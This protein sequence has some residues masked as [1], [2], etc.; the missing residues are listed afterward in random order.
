M[1]TLK[2]RTIALLESRKSEELAALV[3]RLDGAPVTAPAVREVPDA[4]FGARIDA[5]AA[6]RF[7]VTIFLTGVGVSALLREAENRGC[8]REILGALGRATVACRG[9]KP[10]AVLKRHGL[11]AQIVSTKPHTTRE[12]LD[13]LDHVDLHGR[14]VLL[15]HYGE[16]N[17]VV[18]DAV[19]ARGATLEEACPYAWALPDDVAPILAVVQNAID[20]RIDG[21]LFTSQVQCR[22][23]FQIAGDV[24]LADALARSLNRDIVVGAVG[25]VCAEAL[26]DLG[27]RPDVIPA[28]PNMASLI[29][30]LGDYFE[31]TGSMR[32]SG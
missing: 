9:P 29:T 23:L 2:G 20:G 22:H 15:V 5:L 26:R 14:E 6:G 31:R 13:A 19:R 27:V 8:L 32:S 11:R 17:P 18:A 28:A 4:E 3:R 7:S 25:P 21:M 16:R 24:G 1:S 10:T 12:L 30:A